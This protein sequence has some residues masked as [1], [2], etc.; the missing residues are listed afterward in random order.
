MGCAT[1]T[2]NKLDAC[3]EELIQTYEIWLGY[4]KRPATDTVTDIKV[5]TNGG[6]MHLKQLKEMLQSMSLD[7]PALAH[8]N[9]PQANFY[10]LLGDR[11]KIESR[12]VSVLA[13]MLGTGTLSKKAEVL[14]DLFQTN[15]VLEITG[16]NAMVQEVCLIALKF[17]PAY[18]AME[19]EE[20]KDSSL[21]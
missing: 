17:L 16:V 18:T 9:S 11:K 8:S 3:S 15:K 20:L 19:L 4:H 21:L 7:T 2:D 5:F 14:F 13:V 6:R 12:K 10:R 1:T